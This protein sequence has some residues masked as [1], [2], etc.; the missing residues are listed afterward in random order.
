MLKVMFNMKGWNVE[1]IIFNI[2]IDY[3]TFGWKGNT[4]VNIP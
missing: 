1:M 2:K 3:A 4:V